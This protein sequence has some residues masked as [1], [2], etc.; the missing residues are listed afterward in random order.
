MKGVLSAWLMLAIWA[1]PAQAEHSDIVVRV[2]D[3]QLTAYDDIAGESA[4]VFEG[5]LGELSVPGYTN[6]PGFASEELAP[7]SLLGYDVFASLLFWDGTAFAAPPNGERLEIAVSG[8]L[9]TTVTAD[10]GPQSGAWFAQA[11]GGGNVHAH[12]DYFVKHPDW[13]S[14]NP[15]YNPIANGAYMLQLTLKSGV[16]AASEPLAIVFNQN[17]SSGIFE[18]ALDAAR[19]LLCPDCSGDLNGDGVVNLDDLAQLLGHYGMTSGATYADGDLDG[20]GAVSLGDL[21]E[22]LGQYGTVCP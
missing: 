12:V 22:L 10:S 21:A 14:S 5:A 11:D 18:Q 15:F 9:R 1:C 8:V 19:Y 20:D 16:H 7:G 6:D 2:F 4:C 17:L 13:S 3:N